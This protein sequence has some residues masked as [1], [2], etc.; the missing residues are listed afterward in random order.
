[1][2]NRVIPYIYKNH[3]VDLTLVESVYGKAIVRH[4]N[5]PY[6]HQG[7]AVKGKKIIL[8]LPVATWLLSPPATAPNHNP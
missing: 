5:N 8:C 7:C 4:K 3:P 2:T 1:M 6:M